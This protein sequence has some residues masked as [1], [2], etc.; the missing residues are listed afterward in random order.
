M[1]CVLA[2]HGGAGG[3]RSARRDPEYA[4]TAR[5]G[6][7]DALAAGWSVLARGGA[8]LD[9]S[10]VAVEV[11]EDCEVF[12]AGRG[13]VLTAGGDV[14][15]DASVM[16]GA[17]RCAGAV[18]GLRT[19]VHPVLAAR[20]VMEHTPH[21]ALCGAG[22][23]AFARRS[24][25]AEADPDHFV[26][27][28]RRA[29]LERARAHGDAASGTVGAVARDDGG[30]LAA[31]TSTGGLM[32]KLAGRVSDSALIGSG[33]WADDATCA[34]AA[35]GQ[36]EFFIRCAFAHEVD[37]LIRHASL[38]LEAACERALQTVAAAGGSGGCV[39]VD[40]RGNLAMPFNTPGMARG[41]IDPEGQRQVRIRA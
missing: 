21:V 20:A 28:R 24:G 22:A 9:A 34:V 26:T 39:A 11:L 27:E 13:S 30:H 14:E 38:S 37:A 7:G 3:L 17:Q 41:W 15:M 40:A 12:N 8:A 16:D 6:L 19:V 35:T 18:A 5:K 10:V 32:G 25:L 23:E 31:A 29:Q 2:I 36:G 4:D 33:T 1:T